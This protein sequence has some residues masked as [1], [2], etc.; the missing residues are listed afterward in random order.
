MAEGDD[1]RAA[2]RA[3]G[4]DERAVP[5]GPGAEDASRAARPGRAGP[6]R[7]RPLLR[8]CRRPGAPDRDGLPERGL[9]RIEPGR[10]GDRAAGVRRVRRGRSARAIAHQLNAEGVRGPSGGAWGPS[11]IAG[12]V[13]ARHRHPQ[14]RA[15][16]R[17]AGL[18]PAALHQGPGDRQAGVA[19]ERRGP[20]GG[21][22]GAGAAHR[23]RRAVAGGEGAAGQDDDQGARPTIGR[24]SVRRSGTGAGRATC[25]RG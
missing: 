13:G 3:Q 9:R 7:R 12:N 15:L 1:R 17:P 21:H 23:R 19:A 14:Q 10:G 22:G 18:E 5:E 24:A 2:C 11:T 8:L 25:S 4:H 20:A 6:V 16:P